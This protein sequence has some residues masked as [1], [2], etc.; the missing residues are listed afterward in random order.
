MRRGQ[1]S[2]R[3]QLGALVP[4]CGMSGLLVLSL[5]HAAETGQWLRF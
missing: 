5:S 4:Y 3:L 2:T 1:T